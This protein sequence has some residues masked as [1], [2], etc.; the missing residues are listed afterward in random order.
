[1]IE[2]M[3]RK[4]KKQFGRLVKMRYMQAGGMLGCLFFYIFI[5][6][7]WLVASP[8][9]NSTVYKMS[10]DFIKTNKLVRNKIGADFQ[11]M[12][13]N[14]KIYPY[15]KDVMFDIVLFGANSNGK[16]KVVSLYDRN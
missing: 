9:L 15:R 11:I 7:K 14:G 5:Y 6:R 4:R 13:C 8:V 3:N 10:V 1:M 2:E 16:V 12:N